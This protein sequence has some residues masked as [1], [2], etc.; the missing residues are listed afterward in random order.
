MSHQDGRIDPKKEP[1]PED[2]GRV[3]GGVSGN[4][5]GAPPPV[6]KADPAAAPDVVTAAPAP[7]R[8]GKRRN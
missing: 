4:V 2:A 7:S 6:K 1:G 5:A 3:K 8:S